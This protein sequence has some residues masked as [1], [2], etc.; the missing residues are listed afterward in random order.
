MFSLILL[1]FAQ[2][3]LHSGSWLCLVLFFAPFNPI[4]YPSNPLLRTLYRSLVLLTLGPSGLFYSPSG[5]IF[6]T[7]A[8]LTLLCQASK[9]G[10]PQFLSNHNRSPVFSS[11]W[12]FSRL[13]ASLMLGFCLDVHF[14][15]RLLCGQIVGTR[16]VLSWDGCVGG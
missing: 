16:A 14:A 8:P 3:D 9:L 13:T 11:T 6:Y 7:L 10:T 2:S 1:G 5:V 15:V 4:F 12:P